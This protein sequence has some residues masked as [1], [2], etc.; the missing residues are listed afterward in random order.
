MDVLPVVEDWTK[1]R[2]SAAF[3]DGTG[4]GQPTLTIVDSGSDPRAWLA[5]CSPLAPVPPRS[6]CATL[7]APAPMV[8]AAPFSSEAL[9]CKSSSS[10][11]VH[12]V[13]KQRR[14]AANARE[15]RRMHGLNHAFDELRSVIPAFDNDKKLS[16]YETLQMAQIY[17]NALADL[18]EG[19]APTSAC[20][21]GPSSSA[22]KAAPSGVLPAH[23]SG[24]SF[25]PFSSL[26][27]ALCST[28]AVRKSSPRS[29]GEFSPRS[30]FS[31]SDEAALEL[32]SSED[33]EL[34]ELQQQHVSF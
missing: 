2:H 24:G 30:H 14:V 25:G 11:P 18:L 31:D 23:V 27:E 12:G 1:V 21:D 16:K 3:L 33:D 19:P 13:Q 8:R 29:D 9:S 7:L 15:R 10:K 26:E 4:A 34:P 17:I 6:T 5:P 20:A 28:G 22:P 32:Q